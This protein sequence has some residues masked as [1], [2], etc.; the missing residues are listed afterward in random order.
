[1]SAEPLANFDTALLELDAVLKTVIERLP[2]LSTRA[3]TLR[4]ARTRFLV[5]VAPFRLHA[6]VARTMLAGRA[7]VKD[8]DAAVDLVK[9]V[10][11]LAEDVGVPRADLVAVFNRETITHS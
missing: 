4:Q 1:M 3:E 8:Q 5:A 6:L 7:D 10:L 11:R 9:R 2:P